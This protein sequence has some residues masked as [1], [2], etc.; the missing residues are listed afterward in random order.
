MAGGGETEVVKGTGRLCW[1]FLLNWGNKI[2]LALVADALQFF[3]TRYYPDISL[4]KSYVKDQ[5]GFFTH[6]VNK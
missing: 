5:R 4:R 2:F 3:F 6:P 1:W